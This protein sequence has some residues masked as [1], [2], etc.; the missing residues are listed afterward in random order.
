MAEC[1]VL[2]W[3]VQDM[4]PGRRSGLPVGMCALVQASCLGASMRRLL[5]NDSLMDIGSRRA[6][7]LELIQLLRKLGAQ[8]RSTPLYS[9]L[10]ANSQF[11]ER[12]KTNLV[13]HLAV[14]CSINI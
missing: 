13:A 12:M 11:T 1:G 2:M 3:L 14:L 10:T 8:K 6:L 4:G 7:Y 5:Q 9:S